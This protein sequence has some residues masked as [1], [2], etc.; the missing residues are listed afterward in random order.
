MRK[1][2]LYLVNPDKSIDRHRAAI[3]LPG[4]LDT[5]HGRWLLREEQRRLVL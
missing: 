3:R 4:Y 2:T 5:K 1:L